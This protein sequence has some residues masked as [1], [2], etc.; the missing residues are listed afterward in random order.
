MSKYP[1]LGYGLGLRSK[2]IDTILAGNAKVDWFE[3]LA[4]NYMGMPGGGQGP[5]LKKLLEVRKDYP[6]VFHCVSTNIGSTNELDKDFL[7]RKYGKKG[8][9]EKIPFGYDHKEENLEKVGFSDHYPI[10]MSLGF[11]P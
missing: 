4:E 1:S 9:K 10:I 5:L 2:Y 11:A 6:I 3:A 7:K 8:I